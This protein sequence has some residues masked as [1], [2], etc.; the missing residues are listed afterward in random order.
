MERKKILG[1]KFFF[2]WEYG[3]DTGFFQHGRNRT[4]TFK[5]TKSVIIKTQ[6]KE[7]SQCSLLLT[8]TAEGKKLPPYIIFM[9]KD[10]GK[11]ENELKKNVKRKMFYCL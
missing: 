3:L 6:N 1:N 4:A 11:I 7:K 10:G 9:A 2:T 5:G 8:I